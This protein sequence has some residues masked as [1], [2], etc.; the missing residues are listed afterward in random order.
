M[1]PSDLWAASRQEEIIYRLF[2]IG[3]EFRVVI[4][5]SVGKISLEFELAIKTAATGSI[6]SNGK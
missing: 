1:G 3:Y 5:F 4:K 2:V 6:S